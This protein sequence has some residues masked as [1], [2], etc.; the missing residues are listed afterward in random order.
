MLHAEHDIDE[1]ARNEHVQRVLASERFARS[2]RNSDL[3]SYLVGEAAAGRG[4]AL[5]GTSVAQ[6]VFDKGAEF[7]PATDPSIRVQMGRLRRML[8]DYYAEEGA[9]ERC[10]IVLPKGS[11]VP[12]IVPASAVPFQDG[13]PGEEGGRPEQRVDRDRPKSRAREGFVSALTSLARRHPLPV[14]G[15]GL[16]FAALLVLAVLRGDEAAMALPGEIARNYPTI[17]VQPFAN[18][19]GDATNDVLEIGLQ[20]EVAADL[21]RFRV[22]RVALD[23]APAED[24]S[25]DAP[26]FILTG[27]VLSTEPELDMVVQLIS[28]QD[29]V[30]VESERLT[31]ATEGDYF[32]TLETLSRKISS[33]FGGPR[34]RLTRTI[35]PNLTE[36]S[37]DAIM[38]GDLAAFRCLASFHAFE[39]ARS[40]EAFGPVRDCL[41]LHSGRN[42]KDG[43][44]LSALAW[45]LLVG[46]EE[47][48]LLDVTAINPPHHEPRYALELAEQAV[49]IDPANDDAH[50]Y[51]G[52]IEWFNGYHDRALASLR[53]ALK[54][55][56]ANARHRANY[57][58]FSTL[59]GDN[60][61]GTQLMYDAIAWHIDPPDWY[62]MAFVHDALMSGDG[63]RALEVLDGGAA[64]GDPFEPVYR[65]AAA[66][67]MGDEAEIERLVP[68]V[69]AHAAE[70]AGDPLDGVRIWLADTEVIATVAREL[71]KRGIAV[72]DL[73]RAS[74][75]SA[76]RAPSDARPGKTNE[77][78][79]L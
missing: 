25:G 7:D 5:N 73:Q 56:P 6:D 51:L 31:M 9:G 76:F 17:H 3:L 58:L 53:R 20:R 46:S 32:D 21:Q 47:A 67:L 44:L 18:G 29:S 11:Y 39:N 72:P 13:E 70:R 22:A 14:G 12:T 23:N 43:T 1:H 15:A 41:A 35:T 34:G 27:T 59:A 63:E 54:L 74:L 16:V 57:A 52:L 8:D 62:R 28:T 77:A 69:E 36:V 66:S 64:R 50:E 10:R 48:G 45:T 30:V 26:D 24:G 65:L 33:D 19:T 38:D 61:R 40:V 75:T 4:E 71:E 60:Q 37:D 55:N 2:K 68:L 42:P 49:A 79:V 78:D